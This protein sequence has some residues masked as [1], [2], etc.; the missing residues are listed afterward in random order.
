ML[1]EGVKRCP[2][3]PLV[4]ERSAGEALRPISVSN[5]SAPLNVLDNV[6]ALTL[7]PHQVQHHL[8]LAQGQ[9]PPNARSGL[10]EIVTMVVLCLESKRERCR[11]VVGKFPLR[12]P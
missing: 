6:L 4:R 10:E 12:L 11:D 2:D 3:S 8:L 1:G 5:A 7:C 9:Y